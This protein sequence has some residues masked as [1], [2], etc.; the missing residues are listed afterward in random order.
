MPGVFGEARMTRGA[1]LPSSGPVGAIPSWLP[2]LNQALCSGATVSPWGG[3]RG[4]KWM[5]GWADEGR[6]LP[7]VYA[8]DPR[9]GP[10]LQQGQSAD[11]GALGE[12]TDT[13]IPAHT[14][15]HF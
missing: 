7:A 8:A 4:F 1:F 5:G 15:S 9:Y 3:P 10:S 12:D 14:A 11:T 13:F 6:Q 2:S